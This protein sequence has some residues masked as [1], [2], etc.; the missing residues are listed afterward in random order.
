MGKASG[1]VDM[2]RRCR[3]GARCTTTG[4]PDDRAKA[5]KDEFQIFV[6]GHRVQLTD[7][8]HVLRRFDLGEGEVAD[9]P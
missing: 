5:R 4:T 3:C 7:E 6:T 8:Q 1:T 9:L 2:R